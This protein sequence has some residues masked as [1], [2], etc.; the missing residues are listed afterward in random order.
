LRATVDVTLRQ[1]AHLGADT[2]PLIARGAADTAAGTERKSVSRTVSP[3][4]QFQPHATS[5]T[6]P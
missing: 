2:P 5:T 4:S 3:N 6:S 1:A